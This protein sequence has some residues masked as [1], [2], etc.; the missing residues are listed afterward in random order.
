MS[1]ITLL[2]QDIKSH[3]RFI[4]QEK[5]DEMTPM[6]LLRNAHPLYRAE[7]ANALY[8]QGVISD[9]ERKQAVTP[10]KHPNTKPNEDFE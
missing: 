7:Y 4:T 9:T 3:N 5:L 10:Y 2:H 1:T 8:K 6:E